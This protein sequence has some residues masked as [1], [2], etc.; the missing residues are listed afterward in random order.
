MKKLPDWYLLSENPAFHDMDSKTVIEQTA[1]VYG[2][3]QELI[4]EHN[5]FTE[6]MKNAFYAFTTENHKAN[7]NYKTYINKL[8]Y[9]YIQTVDEKIFQ[10]G[11][12]VALQ[13]DLDSIHREIEQLKGMDIDYGIDHR[14][15]EEYFQQFSEG[16][17]IHESRIT[18]LENSGGG[19]GSSKRWYHKTG[20]A[21][22]LVSLDFKNLDVGLYVVDMYCAGT[23]G[24]YIHST[25]TGS[26]PLVSSAYQAKLMIQVTINDGNKYVSVINAWAPN[27]SQRIRPLSYVNELYVFTYDSGNAVDVYYSVE[28]VGV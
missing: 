9:D 13:S 6:D 27:N 12:L 8:M 24:F 25:Y 20:N 26:S 7:E 2:A 21:E 16:F 15:Y 5:T 23:E 28:K 19:G 10:N 4:G 18:S 1:R 22:T 3:M 11:E 14:N 17:D